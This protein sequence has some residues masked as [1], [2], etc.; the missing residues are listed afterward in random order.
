MDIIYAKKQV[1][2]L[3]NKQLINLLDNYYMPHQ[4][5]EFIKSLLI[6]GR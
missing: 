5:S 6:K 4:L 3:N 2:K 1:T